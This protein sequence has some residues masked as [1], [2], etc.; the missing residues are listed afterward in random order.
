MSRGQLVWVATQ[1]WWVWLLWLAVLIGLLTN[2]WRKPSLGWVA[3][4][5]VGYVLAAFLAMS[6]EM[7]SI[8]NDQG[9]YWLAA[10]L[11]LASRFQW[12]RRSDSAW[13]WTF[14]LGVVLLGGLLHAI[15]DRWVLFIA[16]V[17]LWW[18]LVAMVV[19]VLQGAAP[20]PPTPEPTPEEAA[21][22]RARLDAADAQDG[23]DKYTRE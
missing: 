10:F 8:W 1:P 20:E 21:A 16:S 13:S 9:A 23:A 18:S 22:L 4:S 3:S 2:R 15:G 11:A 5:L 17:V 6:G 14:A 19:G 12:L 7:S